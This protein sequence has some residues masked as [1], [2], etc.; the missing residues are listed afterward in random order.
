MRTYRCYFTDFE[1]GFD[2]QWKFPFL[3]ERYSIV[4]DKENPDYLFYADF[5]TDHQKYTACIRI[6]CTGEN[7]YPDFNTCDYAVSYYPGQLGDRHFRHQNYMYPQYCDCSALKPFQRSEDYLNRKFCNFLY[8]NNFCADPIREQ[9]FNALSAYKRVDSGGSLLN[10]MGGQLVPRGFDNKRSFLNQY[11]FT[12]ALENSCVA[13]YTT[14]KIFDPFLAQSLPIYWGNPQIQLDYNP[15]A[16][17]NLMNYTTIE[18]AV[19]EIIRLDQDD[20][21]YL[22]KVKAP[23][24]LHGDTFDEFC[25]YEQE[26]YQN[27]LYS[28][29]DRPLK[30]AVRRP[31]YGHV[32]LRMQPPAT[33]VSRVENKLKRIQK[34]IKENL[35]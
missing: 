28:I 10:N 23:F 32:G 12:L 24:W 27:F 9:V 21:A 30:E 20:A 18:E 33:F 13:G 5:G 19:E 35:F 34:N 29:F 25:T 6:Y 8:T 16:M 2:P 7:E 3:F 17:V 11:K 22:E 31:H 1:R 4:I 26:K 14:E 15:N